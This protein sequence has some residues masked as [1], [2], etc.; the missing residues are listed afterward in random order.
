MIAKPGLEING[1][2]QN[3]AENPTFRFCKRSSPPKRVI[4]NP[5]RY[6]GNIQ[7]RLVLTLF[8]RELL[9]KQFTHK[10]Q[11]IFRQTSSLGS[12]IRKHRMLGT[13][14]MF[15]GHSISRARK[16]LPRPSNND[17]MSSEEWLQ[18]TF[19]CG[20]RWINGFVTPTA[21]RIAVTYLTPN[22]LQFR[23]QE[24]WSK[25]TR[26]VLSPLD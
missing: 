16:N 10:S 24:R 19:F 8:E 4:F 25:A 6:D 12:Q 20:P 11:Q 21:E 26:R 3:S 13:M 18:W 9:R 15:P 14:V 22:N 1:F 5:R 17:S 7:K 2:P 23:A